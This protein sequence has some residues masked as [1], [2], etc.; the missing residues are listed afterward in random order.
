MARRKWSEVGAA[1]ALIQ[2]HERVK[3]HEN[4]A[5]ILKK[6]LQ[7]IVDGLEDV[8][9]RAWTG[10]FVLLKKDSAATSGFRVLDVF[11]PDKCEEGEEPE[12]DLALPIP[13][14]DTTPEFDGW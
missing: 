9:E 11:N 13:V 7:G 2:A 12:W 5:R 8:S 1:L 10:W 6:R 14:P 3:N 4:R